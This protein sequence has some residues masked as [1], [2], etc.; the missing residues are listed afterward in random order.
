MTTAAGERAR[1]VESLAACTSALVSAYD[2]VMLD[3]DGVV[4]VGEGAVPHAPEILRALR[5]DARL[6]YIT[7]NAS[8]TPAAV[9]ARLVG[10]GIDADASDVVT[11]AQAV[12]RLVAERVPHR[13]TVL[14]IGGEGL[15]DALLERGLV[16]TASAADGPA[17]VVQ[18]FSPRLDWRQLAEGAYAIGAGIPWFASNADL[19]VPTPRGLAPGNGAFVA[20]LAAAT[21][22]RPLVA[23]KPEPALFD[24]TLLRVGGSRPIVVG[25]R[26]DTD[27][28]GA[29]RVG[30]DSLCVLTGVSDI[31]DVAAAPPMLRPTYVGPDLRALTEPQPAV[32]REEAWQV[33]GGIRARVTDDRI[34]LAGAP[35]DAR[36]ADATCALRATLAACWAADGDV[37]DLTGAAALVERFV[38]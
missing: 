35:D 5:D 27:I 30:A 10:I 21:G 3:L 8:R 18:G 34:E 22:A 24:E 33:C 29:N 13:A 17:A 19:S 2:V 37:A 31:A 36:Y 7:N 15:H 16:V 1:P 4:Y 20:A 23:G 28:E 11:S 26:L 9:A 25:D 12:S 14:L 38:R 6:A 32:E